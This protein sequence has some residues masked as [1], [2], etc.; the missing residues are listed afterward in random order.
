MVSHLNYIYEENQ[1][2]FKV[3]IIIG[4]LIRHLDTGSIRYFVPYHNE[5]VFSAPI[6]AKHRRDMETIRLRLTQLDISDYFRKQRPNT[7]W[8][9]ILIT[10]IVYEVYNTLNPLGSPRN[11][12]RYITKN[13]NI[14]SLERNPSTNRVYTDDLCFSVVWLI[15]N[16]RQESAHYFQSF[17]I[18]HW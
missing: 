4:I 5:T 1:N 10:N 16:G 2:C 6:Y 11:L 14:I 7:K 8:T 18:N 13:K 17:Y 12:P 9:P 3:N 15:I